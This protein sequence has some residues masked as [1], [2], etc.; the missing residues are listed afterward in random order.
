MKIPSDIARR[1]FLTKKLPRIAAFA[2]LT[3]TL[4]IL[5]FGFPEI[6]RYWSPLNRRITFFVTL[7]MICLVT[8]VPLRF[9][10]KGWEGEIVTIEMR[11]QW[12][13][14]ARYSLHRNYRTTAV[15]LTIRTP[16]GDFDLVEANNDRTLRRLKKNALEHF[17][18]GDYVY[19]S[20]WT[21]Y[22]LLGKRTGPE[23]LTRCMYCGHLTPSHKPTCSQCGLTLIHLTPPTCQEHL[24]EENRHE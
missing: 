11:E 14:Y 19:Q 6:T 3:A 21:H 1:I 24:K 5:F 12:E 17:E 23:D 4:F 13:S 20:P 7:I 16:K 2:V 9:F 8:G 18:I 22:T 15:Q 10:K